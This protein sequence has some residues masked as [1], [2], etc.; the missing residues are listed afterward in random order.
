MRLAHLILACAPL[1]LAACAVPPGAGAGAS[2]TAAGEDALFSVQGTVTQGLLLDPLQAPQEVGVLWLNLLDDN[3]TVLVEATPADAI[4]SVLPAGFDVSV[5]RAPRARMLGTALVSY[6]ADGRSEQPVDRSRVAFGV[7]VVA[8][9]GTFA[10]L[11]DRVSLTEF[12]GSGDV[13]PGSVMA[14]FTYVSPFT[15][16]YVK[17][18]DAEGLT[19]RDINGVASPLRDFTVFDVGAWAGGIDTLVCRDRKLGEGWQAPEV[20]ACIERETAASPGRSSGEI[21]N[22]CLYAWQS[23]RAAEFDAECGAVPDPAATD[24]R[25]S[26]PLAPG[27]QVTLPLGFGD[28][29]RALAAGGFVFLG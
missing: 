4:G 13:A 14:S 5:L 11:P 10:T 7:V 3:A 17:G 25:S 12:I 21:G 6:G 2:P 9:E 16:R 18:A 20:I 8:P 28:V 15:V 1:C 24:F 19:V 22:E 27:D 23:A 29:R 26:R